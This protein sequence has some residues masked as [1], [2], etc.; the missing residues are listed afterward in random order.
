MIVPMNALLQSRP[1]RTSD[2][3]VTHSK[4]GRHQSHPV[5]KPTA[6][7]MNP[8]AGNT[9]NAPNM[10]MPPSPKSQRPLSDLPPENRAKS[11]MILGE[12]REQVRERVLREF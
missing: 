8:T 5:S 11:D 4:T 3:S 2:K 7:A 12:R 6:A 1:V 10:R 9:H